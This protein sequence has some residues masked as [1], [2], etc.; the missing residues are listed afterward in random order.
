MTTKEQLDSLTD[1]QQSQGWKLFYEQMVK[2]IAGDFEEH[3]TKALDVP[4]STIAI[5]RMR[6]VAAIRKAGLR[7][8]KWPTERIN[9][10]K[11]QLDDRPEDRP[12]SRRPVGV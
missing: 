11:Q 7:W 5:D 1:L 8:L 10:L 6:Q 12:I 2:E 9:Q 3:I 4:D